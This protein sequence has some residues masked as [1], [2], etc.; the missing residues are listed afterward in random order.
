MA[1]KATKS[2]DVDPVLTQLQSIENALDLI[3][4]D[5]KTTLTTHEYNTL[6]A[7]YRSTVAVERSYVNRP[8]D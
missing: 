1:T 6:E 5:Y 7:I 8:H 2:G 4:T 3:R